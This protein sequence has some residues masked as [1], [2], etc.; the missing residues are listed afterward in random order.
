MVGEMC[1]VQEETEVFGY[2]IAPTF[3]RFATIPFFKQT[4]RWCVVFH[5]WEKSVGFNE[6]LLFFDVTLRLHRL[7]FHGSDNVMQSKKRLTYVDV[8][9]YIHF[10][11]S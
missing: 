5:G 7:V 2:N 11:A 1:C 4:S 8:I 6:N 9:L 3:R 10:V